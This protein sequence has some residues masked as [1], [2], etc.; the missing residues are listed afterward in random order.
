VVLAGL[1]VVKHFDRQMCELH[2][3]SDGY[4]SK[5]VASLKRKLESN[6]NVTSNSIVVTP[7]KV[8]RGDRSESEQKGKVTPPVTLWKEPTKQDCFPHAY[9]IKEE[10]CSSYELAVTEAEQ[11]LKGLHLRVT[12]VSA[13]SIFSNK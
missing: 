10:N 12:P 3:E 5:K 1:S 4:N 13:L 6:Q 7:N 9:E 8:G 11:C 2:I